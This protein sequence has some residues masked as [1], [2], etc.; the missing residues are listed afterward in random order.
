MAPDCAPRPPEGRHGRL[1]GHAEAE[2][3]PAG[4]AKRSLEAKSLRKASLTSAGIGS[5][6]MAMMRPPRRVGDRAGASSSR[7]SAGG[8]EIQVIHLLSLRWPA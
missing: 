2:G 6:G 5:A 7:S 8:V 3:E 1:C 4:R